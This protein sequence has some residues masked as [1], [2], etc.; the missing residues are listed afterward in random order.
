MYL[1]LGSRPDLSFAVNFFSR[2]QNCFTDEH[3]SYLKQVLRYVKYSLD[4][5]LIYKRDIIKEPLVGYADADWAN[6][7]SDRKSITGYLFE[8]FGCTVSWISRKQPTVSLSSTEAEYIALCDAAKEAI[9]LRNVLN[10]LGVDVESTTIHEDN[11]AC[12]QIAR[13]PVEHKRLKHVDTKC[14]FI[15]DLVEENKI[16]LKY[17]N[18]KE[19]KADIL[20]K[21]LSAHQFTSLCQ[22]IGL[23][24]Q[25]V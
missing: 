1:M 20:T 6:D 3:W 9:F 15:R 12:I 8:V 22:S 17:I 23:K 21:A 24:C 11:Q 5:E 10:E 18:T 13:N 14:H 25:R 16:K 4:F 2:Y 7:V 19:Q